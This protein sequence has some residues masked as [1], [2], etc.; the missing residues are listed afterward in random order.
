MDVV[1]HQGAWSS[2][3]SW[4]TN[5]YEFNIEQYAYAVPGLFTQ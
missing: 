1:K 3:G 4:G 5:A 2:S